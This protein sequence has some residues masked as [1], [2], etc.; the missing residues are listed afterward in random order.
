MYMPRQS[1]VINVLYLTGNYVYNLFF[2]VHDSEYRP[3]SLFL[4]FILFSE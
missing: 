1:E 2:Y 4:R 3:Q